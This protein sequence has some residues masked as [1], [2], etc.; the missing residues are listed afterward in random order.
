MGL[1]AYQ[2]PETATRVSPEDYLQ[3]EGAAD[4]KHQYLN[5]QVVAV[6]G[7]SFA[8]NRICTSLI[9]NLGSQ[10]RGGNCTPLGSDQRVH[11]KNRASFLY[12]DVSVVCG[13]PAFLEGK[14]PDTLLNP[15]LLIEVLSTSTADNDRARNSCSTA[16]Y[17][18]CNTI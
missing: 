10:L 1:P 13:K 6:A 18:V 3:L 14:N 12:S 9:I 15:T 2:L 5:G 4:Y 16:R 7:A 8:H 17:L 11:I